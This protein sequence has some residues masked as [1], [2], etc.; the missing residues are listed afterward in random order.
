MYYE[1]G[2]RRDGI[3]ASPHLRHRPD[4]AYILHN[5]PWDHVPFAVCSLILMPH[6]LI[7]RSIYDLTEDLQVIK[8]TLMRN[9]STASTST[10]LRMIAVEG[11]EPRPPRWLC[12][13]CNPCRGWCSRS[14]A[15]LSA[16][17][18]GR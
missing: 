10:L 4:G 3:A 14:P 11:R 8:T 9:I 1:C 7:G 2:L 15:R 13:R 5:E 12:R 16:A 18:S 17:R 6:R